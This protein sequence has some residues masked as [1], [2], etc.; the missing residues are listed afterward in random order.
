MQ[1]AF[2]MRSGEPRAQLTRNLYTFIN[3]QS[4]DSAEQGRKVLSIHVLH[5]QEGDTIGF[6]QVVNAAN[7][8]MRNLACNPHF[9]AKSAQG[10]FV[11]GERS[12]QKLQRDLLT[13][14]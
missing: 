2:L 8:R 13:Q 4:A 6:S 1:Y 7:I 5:G 14:N 9:T 10:I 11:S 12:G 3:R